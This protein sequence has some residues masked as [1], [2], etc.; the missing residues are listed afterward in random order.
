MNY[1]FLNLDK[2]CLRI[3]TVTRAVPLTRDTAVPLEGTG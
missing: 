3:H 1:P 2:S